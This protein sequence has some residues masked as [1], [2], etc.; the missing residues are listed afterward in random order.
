MS[1]TYGFLL[2]I[3][4]FFTRFF[5]QFTLI[6]W[7]YA[8][9]CL[10]H[11]LNNFHIEINSERAKEWALTSQRSKIGHFNNT[12]AN[13]KWE[14]WTQS[15]QNEAKKMRM[16]KI[17]ECTNREARGGH[18]VYFDWYANVCVAYACTMYTFI[19]WMNSEHHVR[20]KSNETKAAEAN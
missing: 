20:K 8:V 9:I 11:H 19:E 13:H 15:P 12:R 4:F 14:N 5:V 2:F 7:I 16:V 6:R 1:M 3:H 18:W 10:I 17:K